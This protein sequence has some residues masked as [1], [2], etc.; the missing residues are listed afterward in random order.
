MHLTIHYSSLQY[1]GCER[2]EYRTETRVKQLRK[3]YE[4]KLEFIS[5][6]FDKLLFFKNIQFVSICYILKLFG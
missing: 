1:C 3:F 5:C 4:Q 6:K 2:K